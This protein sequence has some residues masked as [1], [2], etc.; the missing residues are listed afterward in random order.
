LPFF[1]PTALVVNLLGCWA[2]KTMLRASQLSTIQ[3]RENFPSVNWMLSGRGRW[4]LLYQAVLKLGNKFVKT[5][6]NNSAGK[7]KNPWDI[8]CRVTVWRLHHK[9]PSHR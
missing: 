6:S 3:I 2:Y 9:K 7:L 8:A 5:R 4:F 1:L